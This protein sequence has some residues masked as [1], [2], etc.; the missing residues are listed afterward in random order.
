MKRSIHAVAWVLLVVAAVVLWPRQWGGTMTYVLTSGTSMQ[1]MFTAG[2]LAVLRSTDDYRVG[3][4]VAYR[5]EELKR[6]VMHRVLTEKDGVYT[7][8]GDNN[9]FVDPD[10]VR[11]DQLLGRLALRVPK[12]GLALAWLF[13]PV[14]LLLVVAGLYLLFADRRKPDEAQSDPA[15]E[16]PLVVAVSALETPD[17]AVVADVV[18]EA[19]LHRLAARY[20]RPVLHSTSSG[21]SWVSEGTVVYRHAAAVEQAPEVGSGRDWQYGLDPD[22]VALLPRPRRQ[23]PQPTHGV[24]LGTLLK[25][26]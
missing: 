15:V 16:Q 12:V 4:V 3:D 23:A 22:V 14:N 5:S 2:D 8:Q 19:D 10:K 25:L 1:P 11:E 24:D 26:G 7:F 6:V 18:D 9:D 13:K 20:G 21:E 17:N